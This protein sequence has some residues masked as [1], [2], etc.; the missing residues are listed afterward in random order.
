LYLPPG[1]QLTRYRR[2]AYGLWDGYSAIALLIAA[3]R[4][5][6]SVFLSEDYLPPKMQMPLVFL[7]E[8]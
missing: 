8:L 1:T 5:G 3:C 4:L 2:T 7:V 6:V